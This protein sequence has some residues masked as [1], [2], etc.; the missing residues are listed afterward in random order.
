MNLYYSVLLMLLTVYKDLQMITAYVK[1]I[2]VQ[3]FV[4]C[5]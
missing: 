4:H 3:L 2:L 1:F 5:H